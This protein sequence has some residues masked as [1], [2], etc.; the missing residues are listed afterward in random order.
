MSGVQVDA[1]CGC[2]K[3]VSKHQGE[4]NPIK[5]ESQGTALLYS[6]VNLGGFRYFSIKANST[7]HVY[8]TRYNDAQKFRWAAYFVVLQEKLVRTLCQ[9][10]LR[11]R[12]HD[13]CCNH[14][15]HLYS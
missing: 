3:S 6:T 8:L 11:G 1:I 4:E 9:Q 7:M 12:F 13:S 14:C 5:C 15:D 2:T 10:H